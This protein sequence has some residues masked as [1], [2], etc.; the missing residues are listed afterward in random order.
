MAGLVPAIHDLSSMP[1]QGVDG[2]HPPAMTQYVAW[3]EHSEM[4]SRL[5]T[6]EAQKR[7]LKRVRR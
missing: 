2:R 4:R 6:Q 3:K 7:G 1:K 5:A